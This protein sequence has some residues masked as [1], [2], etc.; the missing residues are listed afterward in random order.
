MESGEIL[1]VP[2]RELG[3][4]RGSLLGSWDLDLSLPEMGQYWHFPG[5]WSAD[6]FPPKTLKE[7]HVKVAYR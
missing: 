6:E 3:L 1:R 7:L 4:R 5:A 2:H